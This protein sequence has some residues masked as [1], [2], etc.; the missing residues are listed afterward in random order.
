MTRVT[1]IANAK[2]LFVDCLKCRSKDLME[3]LLNPQYHG[4]IKPLRQRLGGH[5]R[6]HHHD[7]GSY[8]FEVLWRCKGGFYSTQMTKSANTLERAVSNAIV[9]TNRK[10]NKCYIDFT[11]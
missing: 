8:C 1:D 6:L 2:S 9:A 5:F 11:E 3:A 4:F 10:R 7:G